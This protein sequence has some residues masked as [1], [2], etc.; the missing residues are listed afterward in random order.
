MWSNIL[1][2]H[3]S[4]VFFCSWFLYLLL[5]VVAAPEVVEKPGDNSLS[6]LKIL[7][8]HAKELSETEVTY[9]QYY[10]YYYFF[11]GLCPFYNFYKV[12][13]FCF[14]SFF[15][16]LIYFYFKDMY[17]APYMILSIV[18]GC[19]VSNMLLNQLDALLPSGPSGQ[20]RRRI[21]L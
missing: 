3:S 7:Y 21:G 9:V 11:L 8:T 15:I 2:W 10:Y 16:Y 13:I 18:L 12:D 4:S 5:Y 17:F 1:P 6:R 14:L 20:P 19:S